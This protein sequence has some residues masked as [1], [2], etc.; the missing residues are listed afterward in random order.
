MLLLL[1]YAGNEGGE[2]MIR[3]VNA[4]IPTVDDTAW[5]AADADVMGAVQIAKDASIWFHAVIRADQNMI[6]IGENSNVQDGCILH[7]DPDDPLVI[8]RG[9]SVGHGAIL[10]GCTIEDHC[11]IGMGSI[12]MNRAHVHPYC[13]IGAGAVVKEEMEIP[14]GS[15]VVGC[16]AKIIGTI[17]EAQKQQIEANARH[18]VEW[19]QIYQGEDEKNGSKL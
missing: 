12:I 1:L 8:G 9:V 18:Y 14:S 10:H 5:I 17:K 11:L 3:S 4:M 2:N 15:V 6:S 16:P 19:K 7:T 13:I